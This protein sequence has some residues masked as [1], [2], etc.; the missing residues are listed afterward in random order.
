MRHLFCAAL[1]AFSVA[2][3][4]PVVAQSA[5]FSTTL[6]ASDVAS[7]LTAALAKTQVHLH[8]HGPLV[9]GSV[10]A[11]SASSIKWSAGLD[12]G[13]GRRTRFTIPDS[14][15]VIGG[16]RYGYYVDHVRAQGVFIAPQPDRLT[17]TLLLQS[18][19]TA[20]VGS[21]VRQ[22]QSP[23]PCGVFGAD[24]MPGISWR[25][26]RIDIDVVPVMFGGSLAFEATMVVIGGTFDVGAA[27][28][29]PIIGARL[30]RLLQQQT[31]ALKVRVAMDV[32]ASLNADAVKRDIAAAVRSHLDGVVQVPLLGIR[33]VEMRDGEIKIGLGLGRT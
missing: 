19:G 32:K 14:S 8:N 1:F 11:S 13:V 29:W 30:C 6:A 5:V 28:G 26:A 25:D 4:P 21:C 22:G 20:L 33:R 7:A 18:N 2:V 12:G 31:E 17:I 16:R 27:C 23:A 10:H 15:R 3:A 24:A 9:N